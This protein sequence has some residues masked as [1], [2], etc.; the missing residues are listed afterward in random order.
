MSSPRQHP[1]S[2]AAISLLLWTGKLALPSTPLS[3]LFISAC[4]VSLPASSSWSS[5][6]CFSGSIRATRKSPLYLLRLPSRQPGRVHIRILQSVPL[7]AATGSWTLQL[8][9]VWVTSSA[10]HC[11]SQRTTLLKVV[12]SLLI[13]DEIPITFGCLK[14]TLLTP[15]GGNL[16]Q[17]H[18]PT[19]LTE[20]PGS[21]NYTAMELSGLILDISFNRDT[22]IVTN[23]TIHFY[24]TDEQCARD[25]CTDIVARDVDACTY[26][27]A[28][29]F[30]PPSLS[31][32]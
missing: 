29:H 25:N 7:V 16:S 8:Q 3:C 19:E 27:L 13:Y 1:S 32:Y 4:V 2:V 22:P 10:K 6:Y 5:W 23:G 9:S 15:P 21:P 30:R 18:Y 28:F 17:Y 24:G 11:P 31:P 14:L 20:I 12:L 26:S